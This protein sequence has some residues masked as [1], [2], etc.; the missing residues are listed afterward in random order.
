MGHCVQS[1]AIIRYYVIRRYLINLGK[2]LIYISSHVGHL[3]KS[4]VSSIVFY[5]G[6]DLMVRKSRCDKGIPFASIGFS[7][8]NF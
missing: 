3:D 2:G 7:L 5:K 4:Y 1:G 8:S 6:Q